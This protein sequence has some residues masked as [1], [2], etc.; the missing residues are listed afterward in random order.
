M[1]ILGGIS[2][3]MGLIPRE[4]MAEETAD[5]WMDFMAA[6]YLSAGMTSLTRSGLT[7]SM[8]LDCRVDFIL[9][10]PGAAETML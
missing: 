9:R 1:S 4:E 2:S 10:G 5:E 6:L 8:Y 7:V 3:K